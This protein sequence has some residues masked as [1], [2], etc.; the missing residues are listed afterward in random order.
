MQDTKQYRFGVL[1][2]VHL[3]K[4]EE[5]KRR[6]N[7]TECLFCGADLKNKQGFYCCEDCNKKHLYQKRTGVSWHW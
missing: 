2:K 1:Q 6:A 7:G 3:I 4:T 5:L